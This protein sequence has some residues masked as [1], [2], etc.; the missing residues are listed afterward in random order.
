MK[1][2][3]PLYKSKY[4]KQFIYLLS[5]HMVVLENKHILIDWCIYIKGIL[6]S[7]GLYMEGLISMNPRIILWNRLG[8]NESSWPIV[9]QGLGYLNLTF[10]SW[11]PKHV[12]TLLHT[13]K[14]LKHTILNTHTHIYST[15][16]Y[17][18]SYSL[19]ALPVGYLSPTT[20]AWM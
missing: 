19:S 8:W 7:R 3:L 12:H 2:L 1:D 17:T 10:F 14:I 6:S 15:C 13:C 5:G 18:H 20:A 11:C 9:T 16:T 4:K